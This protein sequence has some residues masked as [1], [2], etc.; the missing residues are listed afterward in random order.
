LKA[1]FHWKI[2]YN[3]HLKPTRKKGLLEVHSR[4]AGERRA[5]APFPFKNDPNGEVIDQARMRDLMEGLGDGLQDVIESYLEDAPRQI[6][7]MRVAL[8]HGDP[9]DVQRVA[10]TLKSS[11]GI[12]GAHRMV[13]LCQALEIACREGG[14]AGTEPFPVIAE[15]YEKVRAALVLYLQ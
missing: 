5:M 8:E 2:I 1:A 10:H 9:D 12:F 4:D 7:E 13:A 11:S 3:K 6:Q 15:A 14:I